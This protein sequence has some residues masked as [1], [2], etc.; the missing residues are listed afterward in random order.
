MGI[1]S[2]AKLINIKFIEKSEKNL[3]INILKKK[4]YLVLENR[5]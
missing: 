2:I 5:H 3:E 1:K 4:F